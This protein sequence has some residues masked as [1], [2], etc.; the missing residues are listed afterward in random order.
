V[1]REQRGEEAAEVAAAAGA[2]LGTLTGDE[3]SAA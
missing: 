1:V 2:E 3:G